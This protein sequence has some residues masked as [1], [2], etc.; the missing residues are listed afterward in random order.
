LQF[1]FSTHSPIVA[2]TVRADNILVMEVDEDGASHVRRFREQ[3]FGKNA[4]EVLQ[5]SY[6]GLETTRAPGFVH[7]L[8]SI[9]QRAYEGDPKAAIEFLKKL[10]ATGEPS[11]ERDVSA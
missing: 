3:I 8:D 10:T 2:G 6:F 9:S 1:I 7:E 5:S 11:A 4:D